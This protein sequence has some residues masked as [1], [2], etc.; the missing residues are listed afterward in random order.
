MPSVKNQSFWTS[1][2]ATCISKQLFHL[3]FNQNIMTRKNIF[4]FIILSFLFSS[5]ATFSNVSSDYKKDVDFTSFKSYKI[6]N[7]DGGFPQG[8]NPIRKQYIEE[9][10]HNEL[11]A[12]GFALSDQADLEISWFVKI[13]TIREVEI[14]RDHYSRWRYFQHIHIDEYEEGTLVIDIID[15]TNQQ[16]IWHGITTERLPENITDPQA[17]IKAK[18]NE[19]FTQFAKDAK[20]EKIY[21]NIVYK[22]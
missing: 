8:V 4:T 5:C 7:P 2:V 11:N 9:A 18:I 19:V 14:Y 22:K 1:L 21:T 6:I 10:I 12:L 15:R 20:L 17:K 16:L 13:N 3:F